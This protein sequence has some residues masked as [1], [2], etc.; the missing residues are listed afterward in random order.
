MGNWKVACGAVLLCIA[1]PV[2]AA[3]AQD[4]A[5]GPSEAVQLEIRYAEALQK[6]G[7]PDYAEFVVNRLAAEHPEA[8]PY[9]KV[10]KLQSLVSVGRFDEVREL[11]GREPD[12]ES[13]ETWAMKLALADGYY[14]WGRYP[15]AQGI[16]ESLFKKYPNG[17]PESL[18]QFYVNSAY[19]YAQM[20]ILMGNR[21]AA[22][23]AYEHLRKARMEQHIERQVAGEMAEQLLKVAEDKAPRERGP[24]LEKARKLAEELLWVQ[25]LWFGK[26]IVILAHLKVLE[27]DVPGAMELVEDYKD[28][29]KQIDDIL[30]EQAGESG[31]ELTKLSPMAECRYLLGVMLQEQAEKLIKNGG[32]RDEIISLLAGQ[33]TA[34]GKRRPGALQHLLTV[35]IGY[36][37]TSW[38]PDAGARATQVENLLVER[39]GAQITKKVT[40]EQM[41]KVRRYQFQNARSLLNQQ[42]FANA[43]DAYVKVLNLFPEGETSV[44]ALGELARCYV[45]V[46]ED[47]YADAT[48]HYLAER[49]GADPELSNKAGDQLLRIAELYGERN[50][51]ARREDVYRV[52]F[53]RLPRH[54]LAAAL[55]LQFAERRFSEED[56]DGAVGYYQRIVDA[57]TNAPAYLPSLNRLS[58]CYFKKGD[59]EAEIRALDAY[60]GALE[61]RDKPGQEYIGA[62]LRLASAYQQLGDKYIPSAFNRYNEIIKLLTENPGAYQADAEEAAR[63]REALQA[64]LFYKAVCFMQ[65]TQPPERVKVYKLAAIKTFEQLVEQFPDSRFGPSALSQIGTLHTVLED[66]EA[67]QKALRRLQEAYPDSMEARNAL[68]M[69]G[70][71]LLKIGMRKRAVEV[72]KDMFGGGGS[73][74]DTQVLTAGQELVKAGEYDIALQAFDRILAGT[75]ERPYKEPALLGRGQCLVAQGRMDEGLAALE[76]LLQEYP[77]SGYTVEASLLLSRAYADA[78]RREP[79]GNR[80]VELFNKAVTAMQTVRKYEK[81]PGGQARSDVEVARILMA[82]SAA[83]REFGTAGQADAYRNDAIAAFQAVM[84]LADGTDPQVRPHMEAAY[85]ACIPLLLEI[86]RWQDAV[87]DCDGYLETFPSGA[88]VNEVRSWRSK[89]RAQLALAGSSAGAGAA[90]D[91]QP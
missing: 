51:A 79:D 73:Y 27:G 40:P 82:K 14:A 62:K 2:G 6:M 71:S 29:L 90:E 47:L 67:A 44:A 42:Q 45:E 11:I 53:D 38:A 70:S 32:G 75:P 21:E 9:V 39:Y 74:S 18:N 72:F 8:K 48:L 43:A 64:A 17:P 87:D 55:L 77:G 58:V 35:F 78:A 66:P 61:G 36:P 13:Q 3:R 57:Y 84:M 20:L 34:S 83:E 85:A 76:G 15:E 56:W 24:L 25:D 52:F 65:L 37:G 81:T 1:V 12:P 63:N 41:E 5:G 33:V 54:P 26:A 4:L 89:A 69:L 68:F 22:I 88:H 19:K 10:L 31:E 60:L 91:A 49:F 59:R 86:E 46:N 80:R 16:Y 28:Q 30:R 23:S 50:Q 7:L